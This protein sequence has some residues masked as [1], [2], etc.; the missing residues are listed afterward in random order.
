MKN[1]SRLFVVMFVLAMA[2]VSVADQVQLDVRGGQTYD[3]EALSKQRFHG[4]A[5]GIKGENLISNANFADNSPGA[6]N[7]PLRWMDSYYYIHNAEAHR[8][9][10][11]RERKRERMREIIRWE[12]NDGVASIIKPS[13]LREVCGP[14]TKDASAAWSKVVELPNTDGGTYRLTFNIRPGTR[15]AAITILLVVFRG[16][17]ENPLRGKET[18]GARTFPFA[19][20]WENGGSSPGNRRTADTKYLYHFPHR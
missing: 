19:D 17:H 18:T 15:Q 2:A 20:V 14:L 5:D 6:E 12:I 11:E 3:F 13:Q 16:E 8:N 10:E 9:P 1:A 4:I 7:D